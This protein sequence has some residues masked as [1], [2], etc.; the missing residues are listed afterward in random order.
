MSY[1]RKYEKKKKTMGEFSSETLVNICQITQHV[2]QH[3]YL[4]A[5]KSVSAVLV[6]T[7]NKTILELKQKITITGYA[8]SLHLEEE[9]DFPSLGNYR[10]FY[11]WHLHTKSMKMLAVWR[12]QRT[13]FYYFY[14][15][16]PLGQFYSMRIYAEFVSTILTE[17][18]YSVTYETIC[19]HITIRITA[20]L[21]QVQTRSRIVATRHVSR[22]IT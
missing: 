14:R 15:T 2:P 20:Y 12:Q 13:K 18:H 3:G 16:N 19:L 9:V 8:Y 4:P 10:P 5:I 11:L 6:T 1:T 7:C 21:S 22:I 17:Y